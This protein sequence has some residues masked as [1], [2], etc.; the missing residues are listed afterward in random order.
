MNLIILELIPFLS[1]W[2]EA[3]E[4]IEATQVQMWDWLR[5]FGEKIGV[6]VTEAASV[7]SISSG[8]QGE[9]F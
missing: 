8:L 2:G 5:L 6:V 1:L 3:L 4:R 9:S 7:A